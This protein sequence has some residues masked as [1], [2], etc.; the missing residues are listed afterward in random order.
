MLKPLIKG[1]LAML[2]PYLIAK[3]D[4]IKRD[5]DFNALLA[6]RDVVSDEDDQEATLL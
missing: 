2:K 4:E 5:T 3:Q 6:I 1:A